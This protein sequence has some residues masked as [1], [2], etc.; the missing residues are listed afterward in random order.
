MDNGK[1]GQAKR[2]H[3]PVGHRE[4]RTFANAALSYLPGGKI[5]VIRF[6][7]SSQQGYPEA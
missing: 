2:F 5:D 1:R 4:Y 6:A 3:G 7:D